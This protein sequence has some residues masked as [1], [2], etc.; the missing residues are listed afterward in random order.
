MRRVPGLARPVRRTTWHTTEGRAMD[1]A[2]EV[3]LKGGEVLSVCGYREIKRVSRSSDREDSE[4]EEACK[5][6]SVKLGGLAG[7][8][9]E[10]SSGQDAPA[11]PHCSSSAD[12]AEALRALARDVQCDDG[13]ANACLAEAADRVEALSEAVVK[14]HDLLHKAN[15][16]FVS[17]TDRACEENAQALRETEWLVK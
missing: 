15:C 5:P 7:M 4:S 17:S 2:R 1:Y 3:E 11:Q 6:S 8:W 12:I 16:T 9:A 14:L 13:V 10:S